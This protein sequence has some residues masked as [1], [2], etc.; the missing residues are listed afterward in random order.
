MTEILKQLSLVP[1]PLRYKLMLA[2]SL[3]SIIPLL[4]CGYFAVNFIFPKYPEIGS[5]S[6][7]IFITL[8]I[9]ILGLQLAKGMIEPIAQMALDAKRI[10]GGDLEHSVKV[11]GEDE[12]GD[13]GKSLN[14]MTQ[15]IK[16][17][18]SELRSYG[19]KTKDINIDINKKVMALS[20][21]LQIGSLI[22][23]GAE[24]Q[25]IMDMLVDK[26]AHIED[27][28][29]TVIMILDSD[30]NTLDPVALANFKSE[31]VVRRPVLLGHGPLG[32]AAV[33]IT[34][35]IIDKNL[36]ETS[37]D[38][39]KL[40]ETYEIKNC[41][42]MPIILHEKCKGIL[43]TGNKKE[44]YTY[45]TDDKELLRVFV[46]Q[47][48]I[49]LENDTLIK[50]AEELEVVDELTGLYNDKFIKDRL[51]EEIKRSIIYQRPCSF[52]L[53][54]IADFESYC[55]RRGRM[56][57][58]AALKKIAKAVSE[59]LTPV[60]RAARFADNEFAIVL[61]ERNKREA[62]DISKEIKK[63]LASV[64]I[65]PKA[66][67]KLQKLVAQAGISENPIDGASAVEL[68]SK[69]RQRLAEDAKATK[70]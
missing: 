46:K 7:I 28:N 29:P 20:G 33:D 54:K 61:P 60:D 59:N 24:L 70:A 62:D 65:D 64:I 68:I 66:E 42:I 22:S 41:I 40:R 38:I 63:K 44:V 57:G 11:T 13:L 36:E 56:A 26:I 3:M 51:E 4:I 55:S 47:V 58:E 49:A 18:I 25:L 12:I 52:V 53:L 9:T 14:A 15:T 30:T 6:L 35:V 17:N 16:N 39:E 48:A 10:A 31:D 45:T 8:I 2:F 69:A 1:K 37:P 5:I 19:E 67:A 21:L 50:K 32:R 27:S 43:M 23:T 34:D